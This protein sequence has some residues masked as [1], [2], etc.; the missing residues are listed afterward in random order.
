M[1]TTKEDFKVSADTG[2]FISALKSYQQFQCEYL[3]ALE[4][5]FGEEKGNE[6]FSNDFPVLDA[7]VV[8][9]LERANESIRNHIAVTDT[10]QI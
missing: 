5:F 7:V 9:I 3:E 1:K 8:R 2:A 6:E 4:S 10:N